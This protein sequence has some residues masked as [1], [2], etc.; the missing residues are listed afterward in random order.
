MNNFDYKKIWVMNNKEK[1]DKLAD[2]AIVA[3]IFLISILKYIL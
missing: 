1:K 3:V 2:E